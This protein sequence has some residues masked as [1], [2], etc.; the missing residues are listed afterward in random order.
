MYSIKDFVEY[1]GSKLRGDH[2]VLIWSR[3]TGY[4]FTQY[5]KVTDDQK[6]CAMAD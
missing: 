5:A 3:A 6:I 2:D 1:D 4:I